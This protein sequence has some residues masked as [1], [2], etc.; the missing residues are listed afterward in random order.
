MVVGPMMTFVRILMYAP[1]SFFCEQN[2]Q[3]LLNFN[4]STVFFLKRRKKKKAD[5]HVSN[6]FKILL[7]SPPR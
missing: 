4:R 1:P 2:G 6:A 7:C 5:L 3:F